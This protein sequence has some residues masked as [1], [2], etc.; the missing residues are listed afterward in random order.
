MAGTPARSRSLHIAGTAGYLS[1]WQFDGEVAETATSGELVGPLVWKHIGL[2][3]VNGPQEK[4]GKIHIR[5]SGAGSPS[6]R[7]FYLT[8]RGAL[9]AE[10]FRAARKGA[11]TVPMPAQ[12]L[13]RFQSS[14]ARS[15][16]AVCV[17]RR[18]APPAPDPTAVKSEREA[19]M[20]VQ[21]QRG[22]ALVHECQVG[23]VETAGKMKAPVLAEAFKN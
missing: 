16:Q 13:C 18:P 20:S 10:P 4:P 1:E 21:S 3:S 8:A 7:Q 22:R 6:M 5:F 14:E 23:R 17:G 11:W 12:F 9:I 2:C 15:H 19:S